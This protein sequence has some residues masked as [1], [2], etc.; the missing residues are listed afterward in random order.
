MTAIDVRLLE[1]SAAM[2][3]AAE[4]CTKHALNADEMND[5]REAGE[6]TGRATELRRAAAAVRRILAEDQPA[7]VMTTERSHHATRGYVA[8]CTC[9]W[10]GP[11]RYLP[12]TAGADG[13]NH[14][15]WARHRAEVEGRGAL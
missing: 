9:G 11:D 3:A 4:R 7:H 13:D 12:D 2:E 15:R 6:Y 5:I 10:H 1:L 14:L 8:A